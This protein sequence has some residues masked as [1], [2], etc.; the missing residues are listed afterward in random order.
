MFA[1]S[2]NE[3]REESGLAPLSLSE[4]LELVYNGMEVEREPIELFVNNYI[5]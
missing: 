1:E 5:L 2:V 4:A 3:T